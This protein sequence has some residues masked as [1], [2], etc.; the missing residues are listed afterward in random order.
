MKLTGKTCQCRACGKLF[1]GLSLFDR[2]RVGEYDLT[3]PHYGRRCWTEAELTDAG[4]R[5]DR[6][7]RWAWPQMAATGLSARRQSTIAEKTGT[8]KG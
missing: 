7:G 2:H 8:A 6:Y 5:L 1:S 4:Y 3:K